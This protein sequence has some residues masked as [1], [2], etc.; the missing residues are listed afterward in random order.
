MTHAGQLRGPSAAGVP[1]WWWAGLAS[2]G[3]VAAAVLGQPVAYAQAAGP[4]AM[5]VVVS[6]AEQRARDQDRVR[7]L[8][9]ELGREEARLAASA[10]QRAAALATRDARAEAESA[11]A[12]RRAQAN[13]E[14]LRRELAGALRQPVASAASAGT[15]APQRAAASTRIAPA[16][17]AATPGAITAPAIQPAGA[18]APIV[19]AAAAQRPAR[20]WWDVF[21]MDPS[22]GAPSASPAPA[23]ASAIGALVPAALIEPVAQ[24]STQ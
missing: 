4:T 10:Q 12:L 23:A 2:A 1:R 17:V 15:A 9:E 21:G 6:P 18:P 7:I 22:A 13:V 16:A 14:S 11:E 19:T 24:E 20:V 5:S 8:Q 3:T